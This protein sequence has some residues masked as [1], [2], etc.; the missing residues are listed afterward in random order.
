MSE[1]D[2]ARDNLI[3]AAR[4]AG[5]EKALVLEWQHDHDGRYDI[6]MAVDSSTEW[7]VLHVM[8]AERNAVAVRNL[9]RAPGIDPNK[10]A[11]GGL[12]PVHIC[13]KFG[14][15]AC[16][17]ELLEPPVGEDGTAA[18]AAN[19][20]AMT[21]P[22]RFTAL[23]YA[24]M[25]GY[26]ACV[27]ELLDHGAVPNQPDA[28]NDTPLDLARSKKYGA[29]IEVIEHKLTGGDGSG[30]MALVSTWLEAIG[31][32]QYYEGM[33]T[34]GFNDLAFIVKHKLTHH[35][36]DVI[37]VDPGKGGHRRKLMTAYRAEEFLPKPA[38]GDTDAS[39]SDEAGTSS[40]DESSS[41]EEE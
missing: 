14:A 36:C 37:G 32:Q 38:G 19:L 21:N 7:R 16:L 27:E 9:L 33:L 39:S 13:A 40:S 2:L 22:E 17:K 41:D 18:K 5:G 35:C 6:N 31:L 10:I 30:G 4:N 26:K 34:Q 12:A 23:H 8:C 24:A 11:T 20:A 1:L 29:A 15:A 28:N 25:E 3:F